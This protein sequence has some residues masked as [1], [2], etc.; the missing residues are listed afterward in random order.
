MRQEQQMLVESGRAL[1][2]EHRW[3]IVTN[4]AAAIAKFNN[5]FTFLYPN[6]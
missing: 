2:A 5:Y 1:V 3:A 4:D 6:T